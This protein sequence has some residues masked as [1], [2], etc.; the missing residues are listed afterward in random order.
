MAGIY[1]AREDYEEAMKLYQQSVEIAE[2]LGDLQGKST[3]LHNVAQIYVAQGYYDEAMKLYQ[4]SLEIS[5][6]MDYLHGKAATLFRIAEVRLKQGAS[7]VALQLFQ[8]VLEI[9]KKLGALDSERLTLRWIAIIEAKKF[10]FDKA[11]SFLKEA[12][13]IEK[14]LESF[15]LD[16]NESSLELID[17][18]L[19]IKKDYQRSF[20]QIIIKTVQAAREKRIETKEYLKSSQK[21]AG[22]L[23][24]PAEVRE[25]GKVLSGI[26]SE[27]TYVDLTTLTSEFRGMVEK[28]LER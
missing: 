6:D 8:E 5:E 14:G 23:S 20:E 21:M 22:D 11:L 26:L 12:V 7:D 25:L 15:D 24:S 17:K 18:I 1:L 28:A 27:D 10:N 3:A 16:K 9:Q 19:A 2:V 13:D 4:Q